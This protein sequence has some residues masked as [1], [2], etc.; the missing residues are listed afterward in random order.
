MITDEPGIADVA[1]LYRDL[2][3]ALELV[4]RRVVHDS[5]A[6][7]ED[8][9]QFAWCRLLHHRARVREDTALAWLAQTAIHEALKLSHR[10]RRDLSLDAALEEGVDPVALAPEPWELVAQRERVAEMRRLAVRP[11]RFLWLRALGFSYDEMAARERCTLRTV[12]RQVRRAR[13]ELRER[14]VAA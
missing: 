4:V 7:V 12:E 1:G 10:R 13:T 9:C 5:D 14:P 6:V 11:Q 8:A 3:C 2:S